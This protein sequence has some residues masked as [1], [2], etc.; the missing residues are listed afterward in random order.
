M[1]YH[2]SKTV[3]MD[4]QAGTDYWRNLGVAETLAMMDEHGVEKA[5]LMSDADA[6]SRHVLAF[7]EAA[8]ERFR[9]AAKVD[10]RRGMTALRELAAYARSAPVAS[11]CVTPFTVGLPPRGVGQ[12]A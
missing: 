8:P 2:F 3:A 9:L 6:P 5:L 12:V 4:F 10:P 1:S 7:P 11:V